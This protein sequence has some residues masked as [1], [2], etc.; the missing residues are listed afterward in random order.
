MTRRRRTL[1]LRT[2]L[3]LLVLVLLALAGAAVGGAGAFAVASYL[4]GRLDQQLDLAGGRYAVA[5]ENNDHDADNAAAG[6]PGSAETATVGQPVGTLGARS[7]GGVVTAAGV[8]AEPGAPVTI[9]ASAREVLG[10]LRPGPGHPVVRLPGL[11]EY[12]VRVA[13]GRDGDVLITGL[14]VGPISDAIGDVLL[15]DA[16]VFLGVLVVAGVVGGLAVKRSLRPLTAVTSTALQVAQ[17]PLDTGDGS[18]PE[19]VPTD[20]RHTEVGQVA[21]AVNH[22]LGRVQAALMARQAG[23]DQLRRF[24]ADASHELRTPLAVV[25]SHTDLLAAMADD[26]DRPWPAAA[27]E[28]LRSITSGTARM[29]RLVDDLLLLA[30]LDD[31]VAL[32]RQQVDLSRSVMEAVADIRAIA[33][34]HR[35]RLDLPTE[36]VTVMGDEQR[37][38]QVLHNLLANAGA[39]TPAGTTVTVALAVR[40]ARAGSGV[41][42]GRVAGPGVAE[43]ELSVTDDGPGIPAELLPRVTQRF[44]RGGTGRSGQPGHPGSTGLGLAIVDS[45]ALAHHGSL[46][47][48]SRPGRTEVTVTLPA[49]DPLG[50]SAGPGSAGPGA[51]TAGRTAGAPVR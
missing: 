19:R 38:D 28:S 5:L 41:G 1:T 42:P 4:T 45:V 12:R 3:T 15:V 36:P 24:V 14:P 22:L 9:T 20:D 51:A 46:Q 29:S 49:A 31:G 30:R 43:V 34:D 47:V 7:V 13:A 37:L 48:A 18:F 6:G 26:A 16:L 44:V 21:G 40:P 39:H 23:E 35:W 17:R 2:R 27:A 32:A 25:A 11:G 33:P 50:P 8:V 10:R